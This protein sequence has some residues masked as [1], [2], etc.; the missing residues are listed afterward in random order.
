MKHVG[1]HTS[2][3]HISQTAIGEN[4]WTLYHICESSGILSLRKE[5]IGGLTMADN[6]S[7]TIN[8][9]MRQMIYGLVPERALRLVV[10]MI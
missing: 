9:R 10:G 8:N 6:I 4:K 3:L 2:P 7:V 1:G 5:C